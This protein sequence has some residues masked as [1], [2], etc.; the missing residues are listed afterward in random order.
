[1]MAGDAMPDGL[2]RKVRA[3]GNSAEWLAVTIFSLAFLELQGAPS[4]WLH[5]LGGA[6]VIARVFHSIFML[7]RKRLTMITATVTYVLTAGMAVWALVIRL[8]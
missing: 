3:H 5:L 4:M 7:L 8:H 6:V 1:V 2:F